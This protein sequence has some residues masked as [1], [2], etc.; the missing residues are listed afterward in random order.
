MA[1][2]LIVNADDW[3]G[4]RVSTD[5]IARCFDAGAVTS[6]TAMV[7]MADSER[8]AE[9]ARGRD[10]ALG[11]HLNVTQPFDGAG[12]PGSARDRQARVAAALAGPGVGRLLTGPALRRDVRATIADQL[13]RFGELYGRTPTHIDG[14][15]HGHLRAL[16]LSSLPRGSRL[17]PAHTYRGAP[18][19]LG[20]RV[21]RLRH[22]LLA[23][24]FVTPDYFYAIESIHPELGGSGLQG[25]LARS[26]DS[27]VEIMVHPDRPRDFELLISGGWR[28]LLQGATLG[29]YEHLP[30]GG[31]TPPPA[32]S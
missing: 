17:R 13:A 11:L 3:G 7:H 21:R 16:V 24:R 26:R 32:S 28:E 18:H 14:H 2:L 20:G 31:V 25:V 27:V 8:A 1:G 29:S 22:A 6:S 5:R 19:S 23:R 10:L 15:Q 12:V 30:G 4:D 9:L